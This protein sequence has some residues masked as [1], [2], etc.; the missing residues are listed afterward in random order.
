MPNYKIDE[1]IE[2]AKK[3][4]EL[5]YSP[6]SNFKVG[7]VVITKDGYYLGSN[8]EN[9]SY[10]LS[11]CAERNA[12]Y[13]AY[14]HECKKDDLLALAV[15]ADTEEVCSPCGACRQVISELFPK[16]APIYLANL[17]GKL[18]K[19]NIEELLPLA[20]NKDDLK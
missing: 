16:D 7:A 10:P 20:F 15:I 4:R 12:L 2:L 14:M 1:I 18:L 19:T 6:Y 5:S 11:M 8:I 17:K 3:A 13:N 9:A